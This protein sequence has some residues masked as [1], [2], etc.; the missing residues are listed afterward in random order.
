MRNM[1][2]GNRDEVFQAYLRQGRL[3]YRTE[4]AAQG[5]AKAMIMQWEANNHA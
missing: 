5:Y 1:M 3:W 4:S 2:T